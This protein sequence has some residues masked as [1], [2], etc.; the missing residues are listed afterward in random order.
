[1][2][3]LPS[4][5]DSDTTPPSLPSSILMLLQ[6]PQDIPPTPPSSHLP[7]PLRH[8]PCLRLRSA[9]PTCLQSCPTNPYASTP[10]PL[11]IL[12]LLQC[13]QDMP[14]MPASTL[15]TTSPT[16]LI[17]SADYHPYALAVSSRHASNAGPTPA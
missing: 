11:T 6:R 8:L 14:P 2:P 16:C 15:L 1:M 10:P 7:H 5:C 12:T 9:L 13:P 17:L 3:A 4:R